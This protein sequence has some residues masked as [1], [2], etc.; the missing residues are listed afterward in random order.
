VA[1]PDYV[2]TDPIEMVRGYSSPPSR[3]RSWTADRPGDLDAG[4]PPGTRLGTQGPD[5]GY[6]YKL[7]SNHFDDQ[8]QL[9]KLSRVDVVSGCVASDR[10]SGIPSAKYLILRTKIQSFLN[11]TDHRGAKSTP[12]YKTSHP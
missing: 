2:P 5:Q 6:A 4:Q 9:G 11:S 7:V 1:A 3:K 12:N 8:L 10:Q